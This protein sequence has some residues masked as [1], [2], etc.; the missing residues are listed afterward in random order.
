MS[1]QGLHVKVPTFPCCAAPPIQ[2]FEAVSLGVWMTN[3]PACSSYVA[4]SSA[5]LPQR[6]KWL[7]TEPQITFFRLKVT[8]HGRV[9]YLCLYA[10]DIGAMSQLC[11]PASSRQSVMHP[12]FQGAGSRQNTASDFRFMYKS[13]VFGRTQSSLANPVYPAWEETQYDA[14]WCPALQWCLHAHTAHDS[15]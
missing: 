3:S 2:N 8:L 12:G 4:C 15:S 13:R 11:H 9:V 5:N 10:H 14:S 6:C 7:M 1:T